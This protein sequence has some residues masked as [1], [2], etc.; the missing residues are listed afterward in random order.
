[1]PERYLIVENVTTLFDGVI[2]TTDHRRCR[3][4]GRGADPSNVC[5]RPVAAALCSA[6]VMLLLRA[7]YFTQHSKRRFTPLSPD[8]ITLKP[9]GYC[10]CCCTPSVDILKRLLL[11]L[12]AVQRVCLCRTKTDKGKAISIWNCH[13]CQLKLYLFLLSKVTLHYKR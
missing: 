8:R 4:Y 10:S 12:G 1:M 2:E 3:L 5:V 9:G 7:L 6:Q 13:L 11:Q